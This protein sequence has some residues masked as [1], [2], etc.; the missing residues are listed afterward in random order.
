MR[1]QEYLAIKARV[2]D[3]Q[4]TKSMSRYRVSKCKWNGTQCKLAFKNN[5]LYCTA[6][7]S[8]S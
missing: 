8:S 3:A 5:G 1:L 4:I 6:M 2:L 7:G